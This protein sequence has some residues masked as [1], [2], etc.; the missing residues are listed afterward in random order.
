MLKVILMAGALVLS[1]SAMAQTRFGSG[2]MLEQADA[3]KD[4]MIDKDEYKAARAAQFEKMDRNADGFLDSQDRPQRSAESQDEHGPTGRKPGERGAA[5]IAQLD[6]NGDGKVSKEEFMS[7]PTV[8]FD[9]ADTDHDGVL[10]AKELEAAKAAARTRFS[11]R[12]KH[13]AEQP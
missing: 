6:S 1:T 5:M 8:F 9:R 13:G 10:S 12:R 7:A 2:E 11:E 4:G 3:N